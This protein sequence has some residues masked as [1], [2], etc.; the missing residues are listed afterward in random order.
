MKI[1]H[2][3]LK[4]YLADKTPTPDKVEELLTFHAFEIDGVEEI[5]GETIIDV[6]V[7]PNRAS[8]AL[9]HR[10]IARELATILNVELAHDPLKSLPAFPETDS[11][12]VKISAPEACRRF[13]VALV[14]G[15]EVKASPEWLQKR[16]RALGQR[17]INNVVDATNYVMF[18]LGQPLHAYD[19]DLFPTKDGKWQ[20][21][22]RLAKE[23]ETVSLLAEGDKDEDRVVEL[24]GSE[25]LIV[26]GSSDMALGLAGIKGGRSTGVN[27]QTRNIIIEAA[28][29]D[30]VSIRKTAR[31][32][33]IVTEATKRFENEPSSEL[34]V[35]AQQEIIKLIIDIAGGELVGLVDEY[36]TKSESPSVVISVD[37]VNRLLGLDLKIETIKA[38]IARTG[39]Q[40]ESGDND[41]SIKATAPWER[42]D[43]N[44][45]VD[46]IEEV[47]RIN[48]LD[49]VASV[50]PVPVAKVKVNPNYY[51]ADKIRKILIDLGFSEVITS[52]FQ[53]KG[54]IQLQNALASDKSY[55]RQNL[56][57]RL[58]ETLTANYSH[59]DLLGLLEVRVFE[60]G[61][62]FT[63][64]ATGIGEQV[65]LALGVRTK[66]DGYNPK[67]DAPLKA[68]CE[69]IN[70]SLNIKIDWKIEKGVAEANLT[71]ITSK[72]P[73]PA[74]YDV[75]PVQKVYSFKTISPY[76][77]IARDIALWV[78][79]EEAAESVL[80]TLLAPAG[81]LCVRHSLFDTF[82]K[83]GRTSY[84]F[85]L[86]FQA[87][88]RTLTDTEINAIM[89]NLY[90]V[91]AQKGWEVR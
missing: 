68:A 49:N 35:Y 40:V 13:T 54:D 4:E 31:G 43:L 76:P 29:F 47:A 14:Q 73:L 89:D 81:N 86:V 71:A 33:G 6:D 83:E 57:K 53:K 26:D 34:P 48:G 59:L 72:L 17:P 52:S 91:A 82:T 32:L 41:T 24:K 55:M 36:L 9:S 15:V 1:I 80:S 74:E 50:I 88:D 20:F 75:L 44:T 78:K 11:I 22:I 56:T 23:S 51:Y 38:I 90:Q 46:Y 3:V 62:I 39:A 67:D 79:A 30:P 8:D 25:L 70:E 66:G 60:I 37:K 7:L 65:S 2:S 77:A 19:A 16:L 21:D 42:K 27:S 64:T 85:R 12:E 63:K 18:T 87:T 84:A 10:G 45:E 69:A 61:T 28:S 5:E 58:T